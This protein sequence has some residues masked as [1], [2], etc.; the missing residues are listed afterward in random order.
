MSRVEYVDYQDLAVKAKDI[1]NHAKELN[2]LFT[3][4]YQEIITMHQAW[5]GKRY[6]ELAKDF[7]ELAPSINEMLKLTYG[8]IP[9]ALET[10]ANNFSQ[11][12]TRSNTTSAQQTEERKMPNI[13]TPSDVGMRF[14]ET[15]VRESKNKV[16]TGFKNANEKM[17]AI[18]GT[19]NKISWKSESA[20]AFRAKFIMLK[21][22]ITKEI[23]ELNSQFDKLMEQ[24]MED[25][26]I[27]EQK[28]TVN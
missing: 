23:D 19:Y 25:L 17:S 21:N 1:R 27:T 7:N 22:Q 18:E 14:M 16:T 24:A 9:F 6:N 4:I 11:A 8:E 2:E 12:D 13:P 10:I 5:Y 28:N 15:Q 3:K 20:E 26:R